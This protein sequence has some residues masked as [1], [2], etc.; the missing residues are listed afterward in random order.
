MLLLA[1]CRGLKCLERSYFD[2]GGSDCLGL[3]GKDNFLDLR[4]I[5][6]AILD[7]RTELL[8]LNLLLFEEPFLVESVG[9]LGRTGLDAHLVLHLDGPG[10]LK[11]CLFDLFEGD[12]QFG[13]LDVG[14]S[15]DLRSF[16]LL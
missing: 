10:K 2:S 9:L 13:E 3:I 11:D 14:H 8:F 12:G 15:D 6:Q 16:L 1:R 5:S 7:L 4:Q